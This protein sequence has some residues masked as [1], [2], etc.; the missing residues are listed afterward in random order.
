MKTNIL[1][2]HSG[3]SR[4]LNNE[5]FDAINGYHERLGWGMIGYQ[6]VI[7]PNGDI[8]KGRHENQRGAHCYQE[9]MNIKSIGICLTGNFDIEKPTIQQLESLKILL[10][11]LMNR[12][13]I[14]KEKVEP[15]RKYATYKSCPGTLF[16][17][18]LIKSLFMRNNNI[19][20]WAKDAVKFCIDEEIATN[21]EDPQAPITKEEMAVMLYRFK[22]TQQ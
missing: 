20:D 1:L 6:Y 18:N 16:T 2:H 17:D 8:K 19:S 10:K 14:L 9:D 21:W 13:S 7:E 22:K 3:V 11:D 12:H 4:E 5:Q 15:H